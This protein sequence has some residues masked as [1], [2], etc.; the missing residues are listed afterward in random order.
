MT[1]FEN[2]IGSIL[3]GNDLRFDTRK[4]TSTGDIPDFL[5]PSLREYETTDRIN[6]LTMLAAKTT[7][8]ERWQQV[9]A[10]APRVPRKHLATL[11]GDI[12]P[13]QFKRMRE[14]NLTL[15]LPSARHSTIP[16]GVVD[17]ITLRSFIELVRSR[18]RQ[19][20]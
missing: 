19:F 12:P 14:A 5:Y 10:E 20:D 18:Q 13:D 4:R 3:V 6:F 16:A 11:R 9:L 1:A 17:V 7:C 8:R 15:V 2:Q